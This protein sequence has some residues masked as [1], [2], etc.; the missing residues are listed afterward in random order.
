MYFYFK[1]IGIDCWLEEKEDGGHL[2][3]C[4]LQ[5]RL[6]STARSKSVVQMGCTTHDEVRLACM[7]A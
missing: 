7:R 3:H 5:V 2:T 4:W 1:N 6:S